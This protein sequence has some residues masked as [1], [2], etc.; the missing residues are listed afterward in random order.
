MGLFCISTLF[1]FGFFFIM[2]ATD[3]S[4]DQ[5]S[6]NGIITKAVI[7]NKTKYYS[8]RNST[9]NI[10]VQFITQQGQQATAEILISEGQY[11][12]FYQ[13]QI[14][15]IKYSSQHPNIA[16]ILSDESLRYPK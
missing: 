16:A 10:D 4:A 15:T 14:I 11:D 6:K 12:L 3:Y 5:L 8:R 1:I 13:G 9:Q 2:K 7:I